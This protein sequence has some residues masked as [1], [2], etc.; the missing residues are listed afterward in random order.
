[1]SVLI[2]ASVWVV[3]VA[4]LLLLAGHLAIGIEVRRERMREEADALVEHWGPELVAGDAAALD[5][6][7][8]VLSG[9]PG[10]LGTAVCLPDGSGGFRDCRAATGDL[11]AEGAVPARG[12]TG[13]AQGRISVASALGPRDDPTPS[14]LVLQSDLTGLWRWVGAGLAVVV[15]A[16]ICWILVTWRVSRWI[17]GRFVDPI[18]ALVGLA[19]EITERREPVGRADDRRSSSTGELGDLERSLDRMLEALEG[20]SAVLHR[21]MELLERVMETSPAGILVMEEPGRIALASASAREAL[22]LEGSREEGWRPPAGRFTRDGRGKERSDEAPFD[23]LRSL[24]NGG[25]IRGRWTY[26]GPSGRRRRLLVD[27]LPWSDH[28]SRGA[29]LAVSDIDRECRLEEQLTQAQG[30][31][32]VG[33]LAE[34]LAHDFNNL[35]TTILGH[36]QILQRLVEGAPSARESLDEISEAIRRAADLTGQLL[37]FGRRSEDGVEVVEVDQHLGRVETMLGRVLGEDIDLVTSFGAPEWGA[38]L[39]PAQLDQVVLNLAANAREAMSAGGVL[40][41]A[42]S[43]VSGEQGAVLPDGCDSWLRI[44]VRDDGCG[45]TPEDRSR[46]FEPFFTTREGCTGL[47]LSATYGIVRNAGG[48]IRVESESGRGSLFEVLLPSVACRDREEQPLSP[49]PE[50]AAHGRMPTVLLAEDDG[51][52]RALVSRMLVARRFRVLSAAGGQEA[53]SLSREFEDEID[54]LISDI[55]MPDLRGPE[56]RRQ[57]EKTRPGLPV[58]FISG[59][60]DAELWRE[61]CG[62]G[63]ALFLQKPFRP[64]ALAD[65]VDEIL[66]S[67]GAA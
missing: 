41:I 38:R 29:V 39:D 34:G 56:L 53:L 31:E 16:A 24:E 44:T 15:G 63:R 49:A 11:V 58:I 57:L 4:S 47:G 8:E 6:A 67:R 21:Q 23:M 62:Q 3:S 20:N 36:T 33:R 59:Y 32:A 27:A 30:L 14:Y 61:A 66:A 45:M 55:V 13:L 37:T 64:G 26:E 43:L 28:G 42:T 25:N 51:G 10:L 52:V 54:L 1:M 50:G 22:E 35:L 48:S 40:E 12:L 60:A 46:V 7:L 19:E 2:R 18:V 9:T 5:R 17:Q 65:K